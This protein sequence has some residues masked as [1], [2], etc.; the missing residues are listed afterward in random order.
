MKQ[1]QLLEHSILGYIGKGTEIFNQVVVLGQ[2]AKLPVGD[3][4]LTVFAHIMIHPL[5]LFAKRR[6]GLPEDSCQGDDKD[7]LKIMHQSAIPRHSGASAGREPYSRS[8]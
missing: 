5:P 3:F 4:D 2:L 7:K 8:I 6:V 1:Q